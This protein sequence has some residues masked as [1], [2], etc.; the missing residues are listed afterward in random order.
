MRSA[1]FG[2]KMAPAVVPVWYDLDPTSDFLADLYK[3]PLPNEIE[4]HLIFGFDERGASD[5]VVPITSQLRGQAQNEAEMVQ[6]FRAT[7]AGMLH[8]DAS[9]AQMLAMLDRCRG[10]G[11][12][13][14]APRPPEPQVVDEPKH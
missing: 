3:T 14:V 13:L 4:Y 11:G 5:G 1:G 6:G 10:D 12:P 9:A 2:V 7:H 8:S